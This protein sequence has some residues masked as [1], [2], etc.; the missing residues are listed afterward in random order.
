MD[1]QKEFKIAVIT[2]RGKFRVFCY[3]SFISKRHSF[4]WG[5][6]YNNSKK[7]MAE[8]KHTLHVVN[9]MLQA[10]WCN[11]AV[12]TDK[13]MIRKMFKSERYKAPS[14]LES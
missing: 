12:P 4:M 10:H 14:R 2:S 8:G 5:L 6:H 13:K 11:G 9:H 7:L 1:K 3:G